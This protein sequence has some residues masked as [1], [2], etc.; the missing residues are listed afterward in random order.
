VNSNRFCVYEHWRPDKNVCFY[1]G[2]GTSRRA[3]CVARKENL[4]HT[5]VVEKLKSLGLQVEIRIFSR[6]LTERDALALEVE[7][8]AHWRSITCDLVNYTNGGEGASG[9]KCSDVTKEKLR[10]AN[11]GKKLS[12]ETKEKISKALK[13][14]DRSNWPIRTLSSE[15]KAKISEGG[16][17]RN[18]SEETRSKISA[19]QKGK[20]RPELIGRKISDEG[21]E[22]MKNMVFTEEHRRKISEGNKGKVR[23]PEM[24]RKMS[25][26]S[27]LVWLKKKEEL[28]KCQS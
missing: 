19:A 26:I 25:E 27:K 2:K 5:H 20:F 17:G 10:L 28:A 1:V 16:K 23:T 3:G 13:R 8:I 22:R 9:A 15:H 14:V 12:E 7:R 18:V 21:L 11:V 4:H 24:L 6:D